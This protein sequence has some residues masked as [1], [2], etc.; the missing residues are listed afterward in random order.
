MVETVTPLASLVHEKFQKPRIQFISLYNLPPSEKQEI[1]EKINARNGTCQMW[2]HTHHQED[3]AITVKEREEEIYEYRSKRNLLIEKSLQGE[4]P[5]IA[6]IPLSAD[7]KSSEQ[8]MKRYQ[9]YYE[10][11]SGKTNGVPKIYYVNTFEND[12]IPCA[13]QSSKKQNWD[14]GMPVEGETIK[15]EWNCLS[16]VLRGIGIQRTI[17]SG[18]FY[19]KGVA[20]GGI[21]GC[22]NSAQR[23]LT[24]RGFQVFISNV[25]SP[26]PFKQL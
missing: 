1:A 3:D 24:A 17:L 16:E 23:A 6:F 12:A 4:M 26:H 20:D 21:G 13:F 7:E 5:I 14:F 18:A 11:L 10:Q 22:V 9:T 25:T 15:E 8:Q 19:E 2:I